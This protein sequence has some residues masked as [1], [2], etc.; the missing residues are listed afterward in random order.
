MTDDVA[1][2]LTSSGE[3]KKILFAEILFV[4]F[5]ESKN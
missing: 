1:C 5:F 4:A 3:K 2:M